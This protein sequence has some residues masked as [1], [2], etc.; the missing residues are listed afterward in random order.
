MLDVAGD[1]GRALEPL[2]VAGLMPGYERHDDARRA[3]ACGAA[4]AVQVILGVG[5]EVEV[6]DAR[7]VVDVDAAGG[8]VGRDERG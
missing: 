2:G 1:A 6:N 4:R 3:G 5:R 7:D 8:D